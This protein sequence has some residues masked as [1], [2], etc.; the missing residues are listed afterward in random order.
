VRQSSGG[1]KR[2]QTK[3]AEAASRIRLRF[4]FDIVSVSKG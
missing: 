2:N 3:L 4:H 1:E